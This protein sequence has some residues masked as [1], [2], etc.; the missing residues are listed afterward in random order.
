MN[1]DLQWQ[2]AN[3]QPGLSAIFAVTDGSW[4]GRLISAAVHLLTF[5]VLFERSV[6]GSEQMQEMETPRLGK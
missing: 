5:S 6:A 3:L 1:F 2:F 4:A